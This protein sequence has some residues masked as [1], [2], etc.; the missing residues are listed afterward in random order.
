MIP[1][2]RSNYLPISL[3]DKIIAETAG[4]RPGAQPVIRTYLKWADSETDGFCTISDLRRNQPQLF[5][6]AATR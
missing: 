5:R 3:Q 4:I 6:E 1:N 2:T